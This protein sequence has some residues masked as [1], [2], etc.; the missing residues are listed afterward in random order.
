MNSLLFFIVPL[1]S[2]YTLAAPLH[3]RAAPPCTSSGIGA[4]GGGISTVRSNLGKLDFLFGVNN[5]AAIFN[6]QLSLL[7]AAKASGQLSLSTEDFDFAK[8]A[9]ANASDILL[10]SLKDA[11][12]QIATIGVITNGIGN[13]ANNTAALDNANKFLATA[14]NETQNLACTF[15]TA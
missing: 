9:P 4:I 2:V 8:P 6:A 13:V 11:Q 5:S 12:T 15:R 1:I 14:I 10:S 7:D 3:Q